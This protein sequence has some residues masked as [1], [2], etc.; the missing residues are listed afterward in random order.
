MLS[1]W[2]K[3]VIQ[4]Q[5]QPTSELGDNT[6]LTKAWDHELKETKGAGEW[7]K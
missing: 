1:L 4:E 2:N 6:N 7:K 5:M 3:S